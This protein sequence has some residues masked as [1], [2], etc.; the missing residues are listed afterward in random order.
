MTKKREIYRCST[1]GNVVEVIQE[2]AEMSCCGKPMLLLKENN[3]DGAME[4][5]VPVIT[6]TEDG[7]YRVV[8]GR[9]EHPMSQDHAIQWIELLTERAVIRKE[10]KPGERPEA[11]FVS[12]SRPVV[13]RAY[14]NLHGLWK[15]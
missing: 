13:A 10:L 6:R 15:G 7:K 4:H 9:S 14:C 8:I 5:H 12:K 3:E 2:G 11:C 1:C